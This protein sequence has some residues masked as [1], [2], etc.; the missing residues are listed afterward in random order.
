MYGEHGPVVVPVT[1][2]PVAGA[3]AHFRRG[4]HAGQAR[5]ARG[6]RVDPPPYEVENVETALEIAARGHADTIAAR[7]V[8]HRLAGRLPHRLH[9]TPL[10]CGRGS[11]T[12][13][14]SCTAVTPPSAGP[15]APSSTSPPPASGRRRPEAG[16]PI[17]EAPCHTFTRSRRRIRLRI[18][19]LLRLGGMRL[20]RPGRSCDPAHFRQG[21]LHPFRRVADVKFKG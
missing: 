10:R 3:H 17:P 18:R 21:A 2:Q 9:S 20:R 8:V 15:P 13:S 16:R 14:S 7:G 4:R 19:F 1:L 6:W 5:Q 12:T 11:T